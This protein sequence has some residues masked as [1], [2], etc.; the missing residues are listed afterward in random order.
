VRSKIIDRHYYKNL[1][2]LI[3]MRRLSCMEEWSPSMLVIIFAL[4]NKPKSRTTR[5]EKEELSPGVLFLY[6]LLLG[7]IWANTS[8]ELNS[9]QLK[10]TITM[11]L[12]SVELA[13]MGTVRERRLLLFALPLENANQ[14]I[15]SGF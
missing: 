9:W 2:N 15:T 6:F 13:F 7:K 11:M 1:E 14:F 10:E 5:R 3:G 4:A 12:R 8:K